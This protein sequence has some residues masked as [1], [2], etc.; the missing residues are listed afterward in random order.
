MHFIYIYKHQLVFLWCILLAVD[1]WF[2]VMQKESFFFLSLKR[3]HPNTQLDKNSRSDGQAPRADIYKGSV[4]SGSR[5]YQAFP[6]AKPESSE[7]LHSAQNGR[8]MADLLFRQSSRHSLCWIFPRS[9]TAAVPKTRCHHSVWN[10]S[11]NKFTCWI[12]EI[13][14]V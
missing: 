13:L 5:C 1:F 9:A 14:L 7:L 8:K 10:T 3:S 11:S 6:A 4:S 12:G 2:A